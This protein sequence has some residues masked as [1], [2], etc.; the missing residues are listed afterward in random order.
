MKWTRD[1]QQAFEDYI[2]ERLDQFEINEHRVLT[3]RRPRAGGGRGAG[4]ATDAHL[5]KFRGGRLPLAA[6]RERGVRVGSV[7]LDDFSAVAVSAV[8]QGAT[9]ADLEIAPATVPAW[10]TRRSAQLKVI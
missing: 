8:A 3:V 5:W 7:E 10:S 6:G 1:W 4:R 9:D 2:L